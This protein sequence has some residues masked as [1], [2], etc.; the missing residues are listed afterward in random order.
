MRQYEAI[1]DQSSYDLA[2]QLFGNLNDLDKVLR[3]IPDLNGVTSFGYEMVFDNTENNIANRFGANNT[4]I[5]SGI[6]SEIAPLFPIFDDT[7]DY[8]FQ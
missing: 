8:T 6:N 5:A 4:L 7:F 3:Q 1:D 2:V